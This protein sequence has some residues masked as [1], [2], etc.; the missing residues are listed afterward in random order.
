MKQLNEMLQQ[1]QLTQ[2]I[3][4][5]ENVLKDDP[6]NVDCRS[7]LIELLCIKGD[8]DRADKQLNLMV[9]KHPEF[10]VGATNLRQL[11]RAAQ[12]RKDFSEGKNVPELFNTVNNHSEALLKLNIE[13]HN[14]DNNSITLSADKLEKVRPKII[15]KLNGNELQE[16]RDLDDTLGGFIEIFGTDGK[17]YL[18]ELSEIEFIHFKPVNSIIEQVWRRVDLSIK[19]GPSGEA[20]LPITYVNSGT[21]AEKLGRETV[22][23]D[24][25]E[26]TVI[27]L[28]QK[29]W[30]ANDSASLLSDWLHLDNVK[31]LS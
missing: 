31:T 18:A 25:T 30:L 23:K 3:V 7:S 13:I 29:M 6:M 2:A 14:G 12:A 26:N 10:I 28:G 1:G 8:L 24:I 27:G 17:F 9:Q 5:L 4:T 22:W 16:L 15:S 21:D 19:N 20:H 11:I